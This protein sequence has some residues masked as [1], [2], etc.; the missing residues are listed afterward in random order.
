LL[1]K[2]CSAQAFLKLSD[3]QRQC[4]LST[5]KAFSRRLESSF[6]EHRQNISQLLEL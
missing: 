2:Q 3:T 1:F 5:M 6:I 4:G